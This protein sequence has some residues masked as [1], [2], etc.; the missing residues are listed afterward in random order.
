MDGSPDVRAPW[1]GSRSSDYWP[2][3]M[4]GVMGITTV[5][6]R[7]SV[8]AALRKKAPASPCPALDYRPLFTSVLI[9]RQLNNFSEPALIAFVDLNEP[10]RLESVG[11]RRQHF[12]GAKQADVA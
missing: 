4:V 9:D 3:S 8:T 10:E 1:L 11:E 2:E 12:C 5:A 6:T 7:E